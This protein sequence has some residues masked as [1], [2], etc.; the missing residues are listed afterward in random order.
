V[1]STANSGRRGISEAY[2]GGG[3][4]RKRI[5]TVSPGQEHKLTR[6]FAPGQNNNRVLI[7]GAVIKGVQS[8]EHPSACTQCRDG[9]ERSLGVIWGGNEDWRGQGGVKHMPHKTIL[10][11]CLSPPR[12]TGHPLPPPPT[13][14][15][16]SPL[17]AAAAPDGTPAPHTPKQK[18]QNT[19]LTPSLHKRMRVYK[20]ERGRRRQLVTR[21][22]SDVHIGH[23]HARAIRSALIPRNVV[24]PT[25][26]TPISPE[27]ELG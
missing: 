9:T 26:R 27:T 21:D 25:T 3:V 22:E 1:S 11:S 23:G 19:H 20:L 4:F 6:G 13:Q 16:S 12:P 24:P 10:K 7:S 15:H 2:W 17:A 8:T 5:G 14:T 18:K